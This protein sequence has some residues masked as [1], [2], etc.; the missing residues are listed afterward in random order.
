M[1]YRLLFIIVVLVALGCKKEDPPVNEDKK[2]Y[3]NGLLVLNEGL[4]QQNNASLSW[5][6]LSAEEVTTQVFFKQNER[7]LGDTGNDMA[8]YGGKLYL[9]INASSTIE[10]LN[11]HTL[12]S[13]KQV[14]LQYNGQSQQPR[15]IKFYKNKAY[16]TSYD[17]YIN[18]LDT[19][20]LTI[21][22]RIAV[23]ENPEGLAIAGDKLY[24]ANS[25]GLSYPDVD[26]TVYGIDLITETV[27]DTFIV[28]NNPGDLVSDDEGDIYVVKR[29]DYGEND[30][31]ELVKISDNGSVTNLGVDA[32]FITKRQDILYISHYDYDT[33]EG[34]VSSFDMTTE[35]LISSNLINGGEVETLYGVH[36]S[37]SGALHIYD[38][39]NFTNT[40]YIRKFD[41]SGTLVKSYHVGLNPTKLIRYE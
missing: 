10:V 38:A 34:T 14:Q 4:F 35:T 30:P 31:S 28:G 2:H 33:G 18:V 21:T 25:G 37:S 36:P 23:G 13:I 15:F 19:T 41:A 39:M 1:N 3:S 9:V 40:G 29:G 12:K 5:I 16:I 32:S 8:I 6:N 7:P 17:G 26:S 27:K 11:K 24:V 20:T 22:K